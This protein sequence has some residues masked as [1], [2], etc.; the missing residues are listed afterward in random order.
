MNPPV[1][2][3]PH[4]AAPA[5]EAD[6]RDATELSAAEN[7]DLCAGCVRCCT[8]VVIEIDAPHA[9]WEYDQ[10]IW[11]LHH[12]GIEIYVERPE[13]WFLHIE[14][15]C[16]QLDARGRCGIYHERPVL[17]REYDPRGCER[18]YPLSEVRAWFHD[19]GELE[20]WLRAERPAHWQRL[21]AHRARAAAAE[22]PAM[23]AA[24]GFVALGSLAATAAMAGRPAKLRQAR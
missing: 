22:A 21:L 9:G 4:P 17:C 2:I 15:R 10:W 24:P 13:K 11:T 8:Y 19:A 14:T 3:P 16:R 18:R 12:Q 5:D 6:E 20:A 7:A 1:A 23:T